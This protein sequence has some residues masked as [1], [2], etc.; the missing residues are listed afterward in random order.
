MKRNKV[1]NMRTTVVTARSGKP[2]RNSIQNVQEMAEGGKK[3]WKRDFG[4]GKE[5]G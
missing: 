5:V 3:R 2:F 1:K 4:E